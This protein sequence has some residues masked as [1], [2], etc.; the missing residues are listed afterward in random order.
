MWFLPTINAFTVGDVNHETRSNNIK[1]PTRYEK[2]TPIRSLN[3]Y[4][5]PVSADRIKKHLTAIFTF[6]SKNAQRV[7]W[8]LLQYK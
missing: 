3:E 7:P 5:F 6:V 4:L 1:L 2:S 8:N